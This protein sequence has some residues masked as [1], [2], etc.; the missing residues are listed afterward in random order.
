[1]VDLILKNRSNKPLKKYPLTLNKNIL[2]GGSDN[3]RHKNSFVSNIKSST[4]DESQDNNTTLNN[5]SKTTQFSNTSSDTSSDPPQN[6]ISDLNTPSDTGSSQQKF[7]NLTSV[8]S[9]SDLNQVI[10]EVKNNIIDQ[11]T[12]QYYL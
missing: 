10:K 7:L 1:M 8:E 6:K 2:V 9:T 5:G 4:S 12:K 11:F 3:A